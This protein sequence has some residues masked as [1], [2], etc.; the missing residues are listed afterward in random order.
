MKHRLSFGYF[1]LLTE[2]IVEVII[3]EGIELSLE[4]IEECD[5]FF[6]AHIFGNFGM[7]INR[8]NE[9]SYNDETRLC[10]GFYE[11]LKAIAFVYY[12]ANSQV[13]VEEINLLQVYEQWNSCIFSGLDLE[14]QQA[15]QWLQGELLMANDQAANIG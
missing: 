11:G 10:L 2:N 15:F 1:T 9:Y 3:D 4:M 13:I 7:L 8:V 5:V 6:K 14:R 12:S